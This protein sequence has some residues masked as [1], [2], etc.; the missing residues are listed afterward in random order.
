MQVLTILVFQC[1]PL[2]RIQTPIRRTG[3]YL[4]HSEDL[5]TGS[6]I[7]TGG[8]CGASNRP[9][10][11]CGDCPTHPLVSDARR[12]QQATRLAALQWRIHGYR[13]VAEWSGKRVIKLEKKYYD[14]I[15][16]GRMI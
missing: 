11:P 12:R 7:S 10:H 8:T 14:S 1:P 13:T 4:V 3:A 6:V 2:S 15:E 9:V 5:R 16:K